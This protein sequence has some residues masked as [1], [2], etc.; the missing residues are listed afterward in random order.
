M[1]APG[2]CRICPDPGLNTITD[3][4]TT[5]P[6]PSTNNRSSKKTKHSY[7]SKHADEDE[8]DE[9]EG[10]HYKSSS[11]KSHHQPSY[12]SKHGSK[13][14]YPHKKKHVKPLPPGKFPKGY[15]VEGES[16]SVGCAHKTC[17]H[18]CPGVQ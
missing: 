1:P 17:A 7:S 16:E 5:L 15:A 11:H 4:F 18:T 10:K 12:S 8:H 2:P 14:D 9:D 13:E 3:H 6:S